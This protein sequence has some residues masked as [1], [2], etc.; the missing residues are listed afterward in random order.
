M[1]R[2]VHVLAL[3]AVLLSAVAVRA[4][5]SYATRYQTLPVLDWLESRPPLVE[6]ANV[7]PAADLARGLQRAIPLLTIR[8]DA[9]PWMPV[10]GPPAVVQRTMGGVRD[11]SRILLAS[12]GA[13]TLDTAPVQARLDVVVFDRAIRA[14]GW[15]E[16]MGREMDVRD[17]SNGLYQN[18]VSGPDEGDG[19]WVVQPK[20][21]GGIATVVGRRSAVGFVLQISFLAPDPISPVEVADLD[22]RAVSAALEATSTWSSWL[23]PQL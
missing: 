12:P 1:F 3:A 15:A 23:D 9:R 6:S 17:P 11:A 7:P 8:D 18:R 13:I 4:S 2:G 19:V 5:E 16:L 20:V 14:A 21:T 22:A 10:F